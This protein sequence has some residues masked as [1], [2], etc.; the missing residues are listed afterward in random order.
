[1]LS[2]FSNIPQFGQQAAIQTYVDVFCLRETFKLYTV[3]ESKDIM[4]KILKLVPSGSFEQNKT[5]MTTLISKFQKEMEPYI[6]V[7]QQQPP[8]SSV[9]VSFSISNSQSKQEPQNTNK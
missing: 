9:S 2:L 8:L 7:F 5:L 3:D 6:A 1:M 4:Q